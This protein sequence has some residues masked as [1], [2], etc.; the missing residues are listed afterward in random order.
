MKNWHGIMKIL[1]FK[2]IRNN[3]VIYKEE[4]ILNTFHV[5]G[6]LYVLSCC[7]NNN[8]DFPPDNYYI[9][10]DNRSAIEIED[11]ITDISDEPVGNGYSR[12]AVSSNGGFEVEV[13]NGIYRATS[14]IV[15]F[16]ATGSGWGPVKNI[17]MSTEDSGGVLLATSL[18]S[19]TLTAIA[20]DSYVMRMAMTLKDSSLA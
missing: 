2:H 16:T 13:V 6:E 4:N 8:G 18:L 5:G 1:E 20:G 19:S 12:Q 7:F 11:L 3:E 9:G 15:T 10:L 17:F 14:E